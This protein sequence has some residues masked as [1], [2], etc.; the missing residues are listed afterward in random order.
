MNNKLTINACIF[1]IAFI[2]LSFAA[3]AEAQA[4]KIEGTV[5]DFYGAVQDCEI[6]VVDAI[7]VACGAVPCISD[8][9]T[10]DKTDENGNFDIYIASPGYNKEYNITI[11]KE[12]YKTRVVQVT[13]NEESQDRSLGRINIEAAADVEFMIIDD[14]SGKGVEG[15]K[16]RVQ[17]T[18]QK[19]GSDGIIL[20]ENLTSESSK[21][22]V[23]H[24]DYEIYEIIYDIVP[25]DNFFKINISKRP[26]R[27]DYAVR[28][29][30]NSSL[31]LI[32]AGGTKKFE[33][34]IEN[35][36][37]NDAE[38]RI[39]LYD[40][41]N[42]NY[43]V[44]DEKERE[45]KEI[46]IERRESVKIYVE[47][48]IPGDVKEGEYKFKLKLEPGN[49]E[50]TLAAVVGEGYGFFVSSM[51]REK[52]AAAGSKV[53]FEVSLKNNNRDD[54]YNFDAVAPKDWKYHITDMR[55]SEIKEIEINKGEELKLYFKLVPPADEDGGSYFPGINIKGLNGNKTKTLQFRV[56]INVQEHLQED[57]RMFMHDSEHTG[58]TKTAVENPG[59]LKLAWE[60]EIKGT[61]YHSPVVSGSYV[62][63]AASGNYR[64]YI[65][66]F[67]KKT[68]ELAWEIKIKNP[69]SSSPA[70]SRDY[71]YVGSRDNYIYCFDKKTGDFKWKFQ[72]G[73]NMLSSPVVSGSYV[74]FGSADNHIYCVDK[75]TGKLKWKF[76]T[77]NSVHSSP[78]VS[79]DYVYASS[80]DGF[81]Y[82]IDKISGEFKW[83]F[84]INGTA[85]SSP[86]VSGDYVYSGSTRMFREGSGYFY[87]VNKE[88][89]ELKWELE[90]GGEIFSSPVISGDYVY[91][92]SDDGFIYCIDKKTGDLKWK[93]EIG[94]ESCESWIESI[95][96]SGNYLYVSYHNG[97][98]HE[99]F[100]CGINKNTGELKTKI[101]TPGEGSLGT[102]ATSGN[103]LY[104]GF[105]DKRLN[106]YFYAF[107]SFKPE[108]ESCLT[109]S[110]CK[111]KNC[112]KG[113]CRK[114]GYCEYDSDCLFKMPCIE[115]KC[116]TLKPLWSSCL[117]DSECKTKN[118][119]K[120]VCR[121][122]GY[123][124]GDSDCSIGEYC[125]FDRCKTLKS[126][127][128]QCFNDSDCKTKN[129][130]KG[131]CK[132]QGYI[133]IPW[134]FILGL[135]V[136]LILL[137]LIYLAA[138]KKRENKFIII[139]IL[140]LIII[141]IILVANT[142]ELF[143]GDVIDRTIKEDERTTSPIFI[144]I[145]ATNKSIEIETYKNGVLTIEK[146]PPKNYTFKTNYGTVNIYENLDYNFT[147]IC[148]RGCS[149]STGACYGERCV[150]KSSPECNATGGKHCISVGGREEGIEIKITD[151]S[152]EI[153]HE[154]LKNDDEFKKIAAGKK[155]N[156]ILLWKS[157]E[158]GSA[159]GF[160]PEIHLWFVVDNK[161]LYLAGID[162]ETYSVKSLEEVCDV[163]KMTEEE[164]M[165]I[166]EQRGD[167]VCV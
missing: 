130:F 94:N 25:G 64:G 86:A 70:V 112:F 20:I 137:F 74:Y 37:K 26:I 105:H 167:E 84:E 145:A 2:L 162:H 158:G 144:T 18:E 1:L 52:D 160:C 15:A 36:G 111:T 101:Q 138:V 65:Y 41:E 35:I 30:T 106:S 82:C 123:C 29:H 40:T 43:R 115:N 32:G 76:E 161:T 38:F 127:G 10:S 108:G 8:G 102:L 12:D 19:T 146:Y 42:F 125:S 124:A 80:Y 141:E 16:I 57:W 131:I 134:I 166:A 22:K 31:L 128:M 47:V 163:S 120:G 132:E 92:G 46:F 72:T 114:E 78:A 100:I 83:K 98:G 60:F 149:G 164:I 135:I 95:L 151:P 79:G 45:I 97:S 153:E 67:N 77:G 55:G 126:E 91:F 93:F 33:I 116:K 140:I 28:F 96:I 23:I 119:F 147:E 71:I 136:F 81:I 48:K 3:N 113:V 129:C 53:Q 165:K 73:S 13:L 69:V 143:K 54:I 61:A 66:C 51:S 63:A 148:G 99:S 152:T 34:N 44:L 110:E 104:V 5:V 4:I 159:W 11:K 88:T 49:D 107:K 154:I 150:F 9:S 50:I 21:I 103:Y 62:Y 7:S 118:C 6:F 14:D 122:E 58:E 142:C 59:N 133:E 121:E 75:H 156:K 68:G 39:K 109:D 157:C 24:T 155:W 85:Y 90:T 17:D 56:N 27:K 117:D 139:G 87:C 89:G